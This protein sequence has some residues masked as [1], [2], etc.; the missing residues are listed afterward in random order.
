MHTESGPTVEIPWPTHPRQLFDEN[1]LWLLFPSSAMPVRW[2]GSSP[3][4][5]QRLPLTI[6][7][8]TLRVRMPGQEPGADTELLRQ[9][10]PLTT[11]Y[12][13]PPA[14]P[15]AS[16]KCQTASGPAPASAPRPGVPARDAATTARAV[17]RRGANRV[18]GCRVAGLVRTA[19]RSWG[20]PPASV[21]VRV[22]EDRS[23]RRGSRTRSRQ[24]WRCSEARS[25]PGRCRGVRPRPGPTPRGR[26]G[27]HWPPR[28]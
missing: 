7:S 13:S 3:W 24:G 21:C 11:L 15:P 9:V 5:R 4:S 16:S 10:F 12:L 27:G 28:P 23:P 14:A 6:E 22:P 18:P 17:R 20:I 19:V 25:V 26:T 2:V 1:T 8:V